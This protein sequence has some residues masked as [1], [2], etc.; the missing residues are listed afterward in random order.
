M[1]TIVYCLNRTSVGLKLSFLISSINA[2]ASLNRT[3]VG[4]KHTGWRED[5]ALL[6]SLN[7]TSVGLK[8]SAVARL[9]LPSS[10]QSNQRGIETHS[11]FAGGGGAGGGL[12]RTSVGLKPWM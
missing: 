12:N 10:P 9:L 5:I 8:P 1:L 11:P 3:S 6:R 7:R 4:L 2:L